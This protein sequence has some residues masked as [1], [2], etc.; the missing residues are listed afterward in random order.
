MF[1]LSEG[2]GCPRGE[3]GE[4]QFGS[5]GGQVW[6]E[7]SWVDVCE[8]YVAE[9]FTLQGHV[10]EAVKGLGVGGPF[11]KGVVCFLYNVVIGGEGVA[12][13]TLCVHWGDW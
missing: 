10:F 12:L 4:E 9:Q 1:V 2:S 6:G 11:G 3:A 7:S 13:C 5:Q 8:F